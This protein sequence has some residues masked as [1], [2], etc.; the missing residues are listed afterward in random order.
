MNTRPEPAFDDAAPAVAGA[1]FDAVLAIGGLLAGVVPYA[2]E[3]AL[4]RGL[5]FATLL[6]CLAWMI[7]RTRRLRAGAARACSAELVRHAKESSVQAPRLSRLMS[8]VLPVW[9]GH[10]ACVH[11]QTR[12]A[13]DQLARSFSAIN[14]QFES[15]GFQG[16]INA[17]RDAE[18]ARLNLL[19]LCERQ[20]QPVVTSMTSILEG[21]AALVDSVNSLAAATSELSDMASAVTRI[22][23]QTNLL[24]L[25]AAIEAA[26]VGAAG[27]GFAVIAKEIRELSQVSSTTGKQITDR[28]ARVSTVMSA[29]VAAATQ[30]ATNDKTVI[31]LSAS[32]VEDVLTHVRAMSA[33]SELM[34]KQGNVIRSEVEGLLVSLQFQD[35]V[36]QILSVVD[37]DM[38]RL[39]GTLSTPDEMP[40]PQDWIAELQGRYTMDDQRRSPAHAAHASRPAPPLAGA[41]AATEVTFF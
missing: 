7:A 18:D 24:A 26:R 5:A 17:E 40:D 34:R 14:G 38:K 31:D 33:E 2:V 11:D 41:S 39:Q 23:A 27:R 13:V 16:S 37:A 19:V 4:A 25:N 20:L 8:S 12:D 35:R 22:A 15:A 29:T 9:L 21:K 6:V 28:I 1:G 10:V 3:S 30:T 36:S 32:V